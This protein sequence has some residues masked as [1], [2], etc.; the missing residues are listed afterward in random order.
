MTII[1]DDPLDEL[2]NG[3]KDAARPELTERA[4]A[5]GYQ[6]P[7]FFK[8]CGRCNGTGQTPWG[9]C[10]RCK[11]TRGKTLKTPPAD[12][13]KAAAKREEKRQEKHAADVAWRQQHEAELAWLTKTAARQRDRAHQGGNV[14]N[15]PI[16]LEEKLIQYGTL[17]EG[18]IGAIRKCIARDAE[19]AK[20]KVE[21]AP[22]INVEK[23]EA[24]FA[25]VRS[26][27]FKAGAVD[28]KWRKLYLGTFTFCDMPARGQWKAAI[29]VK[30]G[31]AKIGRVEGGKF[32]R[33]ANCTDEQV[34]AV[35]EIAADPLQAAV[36]HGLKYS[37][38]AC[39]GAELTNAES[40][41][42]GIG[43]ICAEKWFAA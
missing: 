42:R 33:F 34:K 26:D 38:C 32:F 14:W 39:C 43:P 11:G 37:F 19:R 12:R 1:H 8:P 15:F 3:P 27:A 21:A 31:E 22:D 18:Q 29:L 2:F 7:T 6:P 30:D 35:I 40:I 10:F 5:A 25:R 41:A 20:A 4:Q 16:E 23:I 17:S 13:A 28:A 24:A 9:V 36:A